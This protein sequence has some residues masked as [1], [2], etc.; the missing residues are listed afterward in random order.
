MTP[1]LKHALIVGTA[2]LV[3]LTPALAETATP[4]PDAKLVP[5]KTEFAKDAPKSTERLYAEASPAPASSMDSEKSD[6]PACE[7]GPG[8]HG[9]D[10]AMGPGGAPFGPGRMAMRL[11]AMETMIGI[12]ANQLDAWRDFTD[13]LIAVMSRPSMQGP[14]GDQAS[15]GE[16]DKAA[17]GDKAASN[18]KSQPFSRANRLA[19]AVIARAQSAEKLQKAIETLK[20][21]LTPEQ[22]EKVAQIEARMPRWHGRDHGPGSRSGFGGP[23]DGG[24]GQFGQRAGDFCAR[25]DADGPGQSPSRWRH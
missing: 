6:K 20:T 3:M 11:S 14:D 25:A 1:L 13:A 10:R 22:L 21:T 5:V 4:Q 24:H 8:G 19:D 16:G 18:D 23:R 12:R 9:R 17:D 2:S 7:H 15:Q